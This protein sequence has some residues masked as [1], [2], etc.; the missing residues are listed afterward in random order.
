[1]TSGPALLTGGAFGPEASLYTVVSGV[2][3]TI[4]F[5]WLARR[6]GNL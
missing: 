6:R 2:L 5:I 3:L 1:M 4:V